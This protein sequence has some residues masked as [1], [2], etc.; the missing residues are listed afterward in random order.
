M[1]PPQ[2]HQDDAETAR[3]RAELRRVLDMA[4]TTVARRLEAVRDAATAR[5]DGVVVD[6]FPDQDGEGTFAV[7]ARFEGADSFELDRRLGEERQLFAV[8]RT[9]TGWEPPVPERPA[10]WSAALLENV[11]FD[12]VTE[13]IDGLVP[14][15]AT[16]LFWEVTTPD[17]T[18]DHRPVGPSR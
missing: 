10:S 3:Y 1:E 8:V 15:D 12:V 16:A 11:L 4:S 5:T 6:V 14:A 2:G 7:W 17:G 9:G 18:Q 13:W